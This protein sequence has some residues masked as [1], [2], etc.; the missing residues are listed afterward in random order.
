[1]SATS[2][3]HNAKLTEDALKKIRNDDCFATFYQTVLRKKQLNVSIT[4]PEVPRNKRAPGRFEVG[5]G[6]LFF[7]VTPEQV[8]RRIYFEALAIDLIVS[9]IEER[10]DQPS[11]K[12]YSKL[13]S[14]LES[15]LIGVLSSQDV[16]SQMDYMKE[17]YAD[18]VRTGYL[19]SQLKILK[20]LIKDAQINCFADVL[21][22]VKSLTDH[23]RHMITEVIV[24][25]KLLLVNPSTSATGERSFSMARVKT[26]LRANM[27]QQRFNN[28]ACIL[29]RQE[30]IKFGF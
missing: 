13:T 22:V 27:K 26:W 1:M 24:I 21:E 8:Y 6:T 25:C 15:P 11:F 4:E 30:Q 2:G 10:F 9:S 16:S 7:P 23:E 12:A 18:D 5:T 20:V 29:T 3:Q 28:V 14:P 19:F 17:N